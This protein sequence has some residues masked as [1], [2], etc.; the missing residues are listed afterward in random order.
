[1]GAISWAL[2]GCHA[3]YMHLRQFMWVPLDINCYHRHSLNSLTTTLTWEAVPP[4]SPF[5]SYEP[6]FTEKESEVQRR[7]KNLNKVTVWVSTRPSAPFACPVWLQPPSCAEKARGALFIYPKPV[8]PI[9][10]SRLSKN[11]LPVISLHLTIPT[12]K[13][14]T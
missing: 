6:H 5:P 9:Q 1:M 10:L 12:P 13:A 3:L 14:A 7:S 8:L 11:Q 4:P 2:T